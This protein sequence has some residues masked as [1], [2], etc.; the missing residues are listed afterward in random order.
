MAKT[1]SRSSNEKLNIKYTTKYIYGNR[2]LGSLLTCFC[3]AWVY[4]C[5]YWSSRRSDWKC[6][7]GVVLLGA[8]NSAWWSDAER[9]DCRRGRWF[10]QHVFQRN[11]RRETCSSRCVYWFRTHCSRW[12]AFCKLQ[13]FLFQNSFLVDHTLAQFFYINLKWNKLRNFCLAK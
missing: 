6:L 4:L 11:R 1:S 12:D 2:I 3:T 13:V 7:L 5:S 9:Q 8:W 10:L